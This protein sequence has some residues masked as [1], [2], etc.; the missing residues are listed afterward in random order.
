MNK[1]QIKSNKDRDT[2]THARR[3]ALDD[4][5]RASETKTSV[6]VVVAKMM[7][8]KKNGTDK[9]GETDTATFSRF[10]QT[11]TASLFP[12]P[13]AFSISATE[14]IAQIGKE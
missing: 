3:C 2:H 4:H 9:C 12:L 5:N 7:A 13:P 11:N 1:S 14:D 10:P 6:V 8:K